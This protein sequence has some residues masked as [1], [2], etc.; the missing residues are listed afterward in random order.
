MTHRV[1]DRPMRVF[2]IGDPK[3]KFK[4][5]SG[6]GSA[7]VEGRWHARG[8][9]VIYTSEHYSTALLEKLAHFNGTL[10]AG[11]H[12]VQ[13]NISAGVSYE[14]VTKDALPGW[15]VPGNASARTFGS[16]WFMA[17]RT[18][19]LLVPSYVAREERNVLINPHH[20]DA[21]LIQPGLEEPVVWDARL[22]EP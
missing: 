17:R 16:A 7:L 14:V 19:I 5:F 11:Q 9:D 8:Q 10:P 2:R 6:E 21:K 13:I 12:A 20:A 3:G 1:L 18:A 4:I 15:C 22:F